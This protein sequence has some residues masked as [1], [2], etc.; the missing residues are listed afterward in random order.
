[1][2]ILDCNRQN[3]RLFLSVFVHNAVTKPTKKHC[4][5]VGFPT[6]VVGTAT[7]SVGKKGPVSL[8]FNDLQLRPFLYILKSK[9]YEVI[10]ARLARIKA[11]AT[12]G[13]GNFIQKER[14]ALSARPVD[15]LLR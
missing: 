2:H 15:N 8:Y 11:L 9:L 7:D 1:M 14:F 10:H 13:V 4:S 5:F 6:D 12:A 3:R